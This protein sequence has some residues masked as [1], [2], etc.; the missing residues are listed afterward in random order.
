[1]S[2]DEGSLASRVLEFG[3]PGLSRLVQPIESQVHRVTQGA[4]GLPERPGE[5]LLGKAPTLLR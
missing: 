5:L 3:G 1:M 2:E 4:N